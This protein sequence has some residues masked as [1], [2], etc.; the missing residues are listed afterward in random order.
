M[1]VSDF[2]AVATAWGNAFSKAHGTS[3]RWVKL[4]A[5]GWGMEQYQQY[6][7]DAKYEN[8]RYGTQQPLDAPGF[9]YT[10]EFHND[11]DLEQSSTFQREESTTATFS[12]S[13]K[14]GLKVG[15]KVSG[16]VG[17]P[18]VAEGKVEASTELSFEAT[19]T[20]TESKTQ[21]WTVSQPI[22]VQPRSS[23]TATM[24]VDEKKYD[25]DFTSD[26]RISG[27]VAIW[28]NDKIDLGG[29]KHWLYFFPVSKV[30]R[31]NPTPNYEV[32]G[33]DVIYHAKGVF[34]GVQGVGT[35]V[36]LTQQK[37][38]GTAIPKLLAMPAP[39]AAGAACDSEVEVALIGEVSQEIAEKVAAE[40]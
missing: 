23:V 15:I 29:G 32:Q 9:V 27:Y 34:T 14:E 16:S 8:T 10:Q 3:C 31:E 12:W 26:I 17:L 5:E 28:N 39:T 1:S 20:K 25:I 4:H 6:K 7:I 18:L 13:L 22:K 38:G 19:Q 24:T 37:N 35:R 2:Q 30:I 11:T 21:K 33:N 36:T 40:V